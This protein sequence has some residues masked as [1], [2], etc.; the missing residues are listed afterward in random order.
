MPI[1]NK[2]SKLFLYGKEHARHVT[3]VMHVS[4]MPMKFT[5]KIPWKRTD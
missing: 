2:P 4:P 5:S 1:K 3:P